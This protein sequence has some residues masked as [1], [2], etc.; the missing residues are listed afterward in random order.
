MSHLRCVASLP[1][2]LYHLV[3][4]GVV[5]TTYE[6][7]GPVRVGSFADADADVESDM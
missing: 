3:A 7:D 5:M 1:F 4:P 2:A 6:P